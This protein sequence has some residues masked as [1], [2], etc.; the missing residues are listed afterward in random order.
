MPTATLHFLRSQHP[1]CLSSVPPHSDVSRNSLYG[2]IYRNFIGTSPTTGIINLAFNYF[3]GLPSL[4][5]SGQ[6]YCPDDIPS[7][8]TQ[9]IAGSIPF[10]TS[11]NFPNYSFAGKALDHAPKNVVT[12]AISKI[13]PLGNGGKFEATVRSRLSSDYKI[14]DLNNLSQFRQPSYTK[15]DA[16][17][18]YTAPGD[19]YYV[20]GFVRNIENKITIANAAT[21]LAGG[22]TIEAP[23]IFGVR[24]GVK[25]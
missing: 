25:F 8:G 18:T 6:Q 22:V 9:S 17:L 20:Q 2:A 14:I 15:T 24:A 1:L 10:S 19:R 21:G 12:A 4:S 5:A 23:R 3:Y 13:V 16:S 7:N 11:V